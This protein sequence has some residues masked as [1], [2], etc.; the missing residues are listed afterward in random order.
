MT[1]DL[2]KKLDDTDLNET[3]SAKIK[4]KYFDKE[5][6]TTLVRG[7]VE[8]TL[9][10]QAYRRD[11]AKQWIEQVTEAVMAHLNSYQQQ[12]KA[13]YASGNGGQAGDD[14]LLPVIMKYMVHVVLLKKSPSVGFHS[15]TSAIW[16]PSTDGMCSVTWENETMHLLVTVFEVK[17]R[18]S[19]G[20]FAK[21][22]KKIIWQTL[23]DLPNHLADLPTSWQTF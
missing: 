2:A 10:N 17:G 9:G 18:P 20:S 14:G 21:S 23:A 6:I 16:D 4:S 22:T 3:K 1:D 12:K 15:A 5:K 11:L 7:A 13:E 8:Q 19:P